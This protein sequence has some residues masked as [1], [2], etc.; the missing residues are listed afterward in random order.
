MDEAVEPVLL[1][2]K[3]RNVWLVASLR[4]ALENY[5]YLPN[6]PCV[7][8]ESFEALIARVRRLRR[9]DPT[10]VIVVSLHWG[11]E[12]TLKPVPRQRVDAHQIV[13]AGADVLVCHHTHTL[14]TV[15]DY[16]GHKIFYSIGNFIF[17]QQEAINTKTCMVRLR[18]GP[19]TIS[20]DS[21]PVTIRRCV[22]YLQ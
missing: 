12:H 14:Q 9:T 4:L 19:I 21:L 11:A 2:A 16:R 10:A 7:S 22:P 1:T 3:P 18:V 17:D 20:V 5:A 8:Q 6:Q 15:E 13:D